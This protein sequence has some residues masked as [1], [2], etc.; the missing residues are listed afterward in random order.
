MN[1][2]LL[3][4]LAV[5]GAAS[6]QYLAAPIPYARDAVPIHE[7]QQEAG[8][9]SLAHPAVVNNALREAQYPAEWT[10]DQYKNPKIAAALARESWLTDKEMP[11]FDRVADKI[12]REQVFKI[13][14]NAGFI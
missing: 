10:N 8:Y 6:A 9:S 5:L 11:V 3:F 13:F 2:I 1:S 14:N 12:P 4:T 7:N